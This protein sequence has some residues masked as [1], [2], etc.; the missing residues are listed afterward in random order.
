[1]AE[2]VAILMYH[3]VSAG[4]CRGPYTVSAERFAHDL[5]LARDEGAV[6][7]EFTFDDGWSGSYLHGLEPL[8]QHGGGA[9]VFVTT[10]FLGKPGFMTEQMLRTWHARGLRVGSHAITHR[11]L[12]VLPER[13]IRR[14][15]VDSKARL[16]DLVGTSVDAF[17]V[18]GGNLDA[19]V[20]DLALEHYARIYTSR[21]AFAHA[22]DRVLPRFTIR[23][24]TPRDALRWLRSGH[25]GSLFVGDRLRW[26]AK[27]TLGVP[28][29]L[30]L[31]GFVRRTRMR[32][33][34]ESSRSS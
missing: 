20:R 3:D 22:G 8:A 31:R 27:Q 14:E 16:E 9:T 29:Y 30:A 19:R 4:E 2:R 5:A 6:R 21:P 25:T 26:A 28:L 1:M 15:L 33:R 17:A 12:T 32:A 24:R 11:P 23:E 34:P 13:E 7:V 18:P 10:D